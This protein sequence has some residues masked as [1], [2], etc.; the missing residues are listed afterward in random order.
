MN[1]TDH[2]AAHA[3]ITYTHC[4]THYHHTSPYTHCRH[5]IHYHHTDIHHHTDIQI[6]NYSRWTLFIKHHYQNIITITKI[7]LMLPSSVLIR[8]GRIFFLYSKTSL[9]KTFNIIIYGNIN[10]EYINTYSAI[11]FINY[12]L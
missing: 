8:R 4:G 6:I 7:V 12:T 5:T 9:N 10:G 1:C 3:V 2:V 11:S